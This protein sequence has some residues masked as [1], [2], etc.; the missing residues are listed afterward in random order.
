MEKVD[1]EKQAEL[2]DRY[3][4]SIVKFFSKFSLSLLPSDIISISLN[5][6]SLPSFR[7]IIRSAEATSAVIF[8]FENKDLDYS[9]QISDKKGW[10]E[11]HCPLHPKMSDIAYISFTGCTFQQSDCGVFIY[12]LYGV[13]CQLHPYVQSRH[14]I[15]GTMRWF[16][17]EELSVSY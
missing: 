4:L 14:L 9:L 12:D 5:Y 7:A 1:G 2:L 17:C 11:D 15:F 3:S 16:Y 13:P 10:T 6:H 8:L